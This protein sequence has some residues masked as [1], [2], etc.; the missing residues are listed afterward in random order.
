MSESGT[1]KLKDGVPDPNPPE[2]GRPLP[3][4]ETAAEQARAAEESREARDAQASNRERMVD[5]GRG[6]Q[7]A[8]RHAK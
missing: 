8:G 5:I 1:G 4:H 7:Q 6:A 2:H 3:T